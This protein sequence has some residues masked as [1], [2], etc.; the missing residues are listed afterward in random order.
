MCFDCTFSN[1][2]LPVS[3]RPKMAKIHQF[4]LLSRTCH[5]VNKAMWTG[6]CPVSDSLDQRKF[7]HV[8]RCVNGGTVNVLAYRLDVYLFMAGVVRRREE[9][10]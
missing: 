5:V 8:H 3:I 7:S 2:L 9:K 10:G 6:Y 1:N 4:S